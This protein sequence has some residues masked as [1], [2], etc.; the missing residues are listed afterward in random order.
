MRVLAVVALLL[1]VAVVGWFATS[2]SSDPRPDA[3][4]RGSGEL[5]EPPAGPAAAVGVPAGTVAI[6]ANDERPP[7]AG[8]ADAPTACIVVVEYG[9]STPVA[10]A[11]VRRVANGD[12][13]AFTDDQGKAL[14]ALKERE[15]LAVVRDGF[16]LR[17]APTEVGSTE[18]APQRVQLVRDRWSP[19]LVLSLR[20]PDGSAVVDAFVR[21]RGDATPAAAPSPVPPRDV[22]VERAWIE[23]GMLAGRP[24]C[25]DVPVELGTYAEGRVHRLANEQEIR[26]VVPG[27]YEAEIATLGGFVARTRVLVAAGPSPQRVEVRLVA[28][29]RIA[30]TVVGADGATPVTGATVS[31]DG[32][33][34]LGLVAT[35]SATG[36]F[37]LAPVLPGPTTLAIRH[38]DHEAKA[39]GPLAPPVGNLRI[40]LVPL[41]A[42]SIRGRVRSRPGLLPIAGATVSWMVV[43]AAPV[44]AKTG[45]DGTFVVRATGKEPARLVVRAIEHITYAEL[46]DP[47]AA[48]ADYDLLPATL[49]A[50]LAAKLSALLEGVVVDSQGLPAAGV[51]LRWEPTARAAPDFVPGRRVLEGG[52]LDLPLFATT[53]QDGAFR[54]ET[55]HF[56]PGR[57][58]AAG[59]AAGPGLDA[60]ATPGTASTG[61]RLQR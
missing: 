36:A 49:D 11:A 19:R 46:V 44:T 58:V 25:G 8:L 18:Q 42:S 23:H 53:G 39:L 55:H 5:G 43:G 16:L 40:Q 28:G 51:T 47:G 35:T 3:G 1:V 10:G 59:G 15:Q 6:R 45:A 20:A 32:G 26:F 56:G 24:V 4:A 2:G 31:V 12:E 13:I 22:V 41:P 33:D 7:A 57:L 14:L 27:A 52:A 34:P 30:G 54:L 17:L 60:V 48:F 37:E 9:T 21:F 38:V 29:E 50:R 61:L